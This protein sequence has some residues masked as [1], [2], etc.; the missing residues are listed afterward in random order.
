MKLVFQMMVRWATCQELAENKDDIERLAQHYWD[1][2]KSATP[3]ALLLPWFPSRAKKVQRNSTRALF[4]LFY[5]YVILRRKAPVPS[6]DSIDTLIA[7]G[8]TDEAIVGVSP[9]Y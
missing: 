3:V 2:E 9:S 1:L 4:T 5:K 7:Y 8:D 6:S